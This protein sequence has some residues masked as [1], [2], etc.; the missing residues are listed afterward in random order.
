MKAIATN[1]MRRFFGRSKMVFNR[2]WQLS[3]AKERSTRSAAIPR[4]NARVGERAREWGCSARQMPAGTNRPS[5]PRARLAKVPPAQPGGI[6]RRGHCQ[7][8]DAERLTGL[9]LAR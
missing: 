8:G 1:A 4:A 5:R 9:A 2:R 7:N 6:A 3:L